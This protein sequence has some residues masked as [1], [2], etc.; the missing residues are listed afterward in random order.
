MSIS[1]IS[2]GRL[3]G[4]NT[5]PVAKWA[6]F[7]PA[8]SPTPAVP[9]P[10]TFPQRGAPFFLIQRAHFLLTFDIYKAGAKAKAKLPI[11]LR[12]VPF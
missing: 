4:R 8:P 11:T 9:I 3:S 1:K 10:R 6:L 7:L 12:N 5:V 2:S